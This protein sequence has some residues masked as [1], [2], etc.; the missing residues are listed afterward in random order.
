MNVFKIVIT[1][2]F[3]VISS[4]SFALTDA[5]RGIFDL[6]F[7]APE[8]AEPSDQ[9]SPIQC[10]IHFVDIQDAR[11]NKETI[12]ASGSKPLR[13]RAV[14]NWLQ[15]YKSD[16]LDQLPYDPDKQKIDI[17]VELLR[18]YSYAQGA[19]IRGVVA[20]KLSLESENVNEVIFLRGYSS[21]TNWNNLTGEYADAVNKAGYDL[22]LTIED[23]LREHC[24]DGG[25]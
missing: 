21:R 14:D 12:G 20:A 16:I 11:D 23:T 9:K 19:S 22:A 5:D 15:Q 10:A 4:H 2:T 3:L 17:N 1:L 18:M 25:A 7:T 8:V 13:A 6:I 24:S